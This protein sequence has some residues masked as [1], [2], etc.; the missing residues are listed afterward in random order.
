[1]YAALVEVL[2]HRN[3]FAQAAGQSVE[4]P[5]YERVILLQSLEAM[6]KGRAL[7]GGFCS[8]ICALCGTFEFN[9]RGHR[10]RQ[11][12]IVPIC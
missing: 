8:L 2:Q 6:K 1:M 5:N 12:R 9:S 11:S 4:F 10:Q 3:E 7:D